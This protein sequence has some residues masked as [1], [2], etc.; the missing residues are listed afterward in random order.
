MPP[1]VPASVPFASTVPETLTTPAL[2]PSRVMAPLRLLMRVGADHAVGI[3]DGVEQRVG[4]LRGQQDVAAVGFDGALVHRGRVERCL[5]DGDLDQAVADHVEGDLVA[6]GEGNRA[7][8]RGDDAFV[9]DLRPEQR[10]I[11]VRRDD[12]ARC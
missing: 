10:D 5:V 12:A 3:D 4:A 2:P 8:A 7:H 1:V 9:R 11:A 6:R